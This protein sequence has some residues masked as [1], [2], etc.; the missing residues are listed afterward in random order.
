MSSLADLDRT[1]IRGR[2]P[3]QQRVKQNARTHISRNGPAGRPSMSFPRGLRRLSCG[4]LRRSAGVFSDHFI[5]ALLV[6]LGP[7][8]RAF[9]Q[10]DKSW[11][12]RC[13]TDGRE[14][15]L[16]GFADWMMPA[17]SFPASLEGRLRKGEPPLRSSRGML[18]QESKRGGTTS[19][20]CR[21]TERS[22]RVGGAAEP[23]HGYSGRTVKGDLPGPS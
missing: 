22:F 17:F 18:G 3:R 8:G 9:E 13:H 7:R 11:A 14:R 21:I 19:T 15:A 2:G 12:C 20:A 5:L 16:P 6:E 10:S 1:K 4:P 23:A